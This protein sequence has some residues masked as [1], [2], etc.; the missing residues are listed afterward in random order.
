MV[1]S[2]SWIGGLFHRV[3]TRQNDKFVDYPLTP[4]EE[5]RL[6][7]LQERLQVPYDETN[8]DHQESLR[9]LWQCSFPNVCLN[10]MIT[11]QWKEM[12]WQGANPSTDFRGCGIISLENLL[13]FARKYP[14]SFHKLM[15]KKEGERATW[16]YPF[17]AA[18]VNIS[19][20]LIQLLDLCPGGATNNTD[21]IGE[22]VI[23]RRFKPNTRLACLQSV[24]LIA[25][26]F[27]TCPYTTNSKM[28]NFVSTADNPVKMSILVALRDSSRL[29]NGFVPVTF[30]AVYI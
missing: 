5:E 14:A 21:A 17:A 24:V 30:E 9:A 13:F 28:Y 8:P 25:L 19:Y 22:R 18:G 6:Q 1:G 23:V 10:G 2:R 7:R 16:E 4:L 15:L 26:I 3:N 20:M 11:D 29:L 27:C 12:G